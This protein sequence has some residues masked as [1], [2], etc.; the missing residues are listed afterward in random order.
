M[1]FLLNRG[2]LRVDSQETQGLFNKTARP[3]GYLLIWTVGSRSDDSDAFQFGWSD[4]N[5]GG[6]S[7]RS[8][9]HG[10]SDP[11]D[12]DLMAR[13]KGVLWI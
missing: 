2:G 8:D 9:L 12:L 10:R 6:G 7:G 1:E 3:K 5:M 13:F 4:L 11:L